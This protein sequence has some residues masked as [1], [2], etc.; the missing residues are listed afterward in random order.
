[1]EPTVEVGSDLLFTELLDSTVPTFTV[2]S[3][4]EDCDG[5]APGGGVGGGCGSS[6]AS[7]V[8]FEDDDPPIGE[9]DP[10][11]R[12]RN[13]AGSYE[14]VVL[15]RSSDPSGVPRRRLHVRGVQAA[16]GRRC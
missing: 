1:M 8:N 13:L 2:A 10:T 6:R 9:G 14:Y 7:F 11:V 15:G 4:L 5:A 3:I 16:L 12:D